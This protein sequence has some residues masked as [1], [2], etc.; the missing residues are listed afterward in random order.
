[1]DRSGKAAVNRRGFIKGLAGLAA[2]TVAPGIPFAQAKSDYERFISM[3]R[4]GTVVGQTFYIDGPIILERL[5]NLLVERCRFV[6][7]RELTTNEPICAM[8]HCSDV[9]LRNCVFEVP[10]SYEGWM[11]V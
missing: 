5:S 6:I 1:V 9:L 10:H 7:T 4:T 11:K 8:R 3:A 2:L